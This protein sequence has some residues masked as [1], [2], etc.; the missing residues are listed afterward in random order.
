MLVLGNFYYKLDRL[1]LLKNYKIIYNYPKELMI[2]V[3]YL[4]FGV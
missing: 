4:Y 3:K 1:F 2:Y